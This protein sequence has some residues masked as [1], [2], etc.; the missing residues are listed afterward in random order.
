MGLD[1]IQWGCSYVPLIEV[2]RNV[3]ILVKQSCEWVIILSNG[4]AS[5]KNQIV[6]ENTEKQRCT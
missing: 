5:R 2:P 4:K 1:L 6:Y 3:I